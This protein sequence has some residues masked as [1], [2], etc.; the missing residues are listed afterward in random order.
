MTVPS[1]IQNYQRQSYVT[2]LHKF[3]NELSQ[4][5][6]QYQAERNALNLKEAGLTSQDALND[7]FKTRFKVV[8]DCGNTTVPCFA[9]NEEYRKLNASDQI[10]TVLLSSLSIA[11]GAAVTF[12]LTITGE[13]IASLYVDINGAKGPNIAGRDIFA[14]YIYNDG[15]IDDWTA[16]GSKPD[17]DVRELNYNLDCR[18]A[19]NGWTG[20]F[21]KILNDNWQMT[22]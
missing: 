13:R 8:N 5:L 2:Q 11:S 15:T 7:F 9:P 19:N 17:K 20:C 16:D 18:S 22:Y 14:I 10:G 1:L 12:Q 6:I 4:A 3:Y 21:G